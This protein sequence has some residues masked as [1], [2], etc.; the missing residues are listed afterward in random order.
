M[1]NKTLIHKQVYNITSQEDIPD[2]SVKKI[3]RIISSSPKALSS[4]SK[5]ELDQFPVKFRNVI[6]GTRKDLTLHYSIKGAKTVYKD[7]AEF[8]GIKY[9]DTI[10]Y[11]ESENT[12][13]KVDYVF[14]FTKPKENITE[15]RIYQIGPRYSNK[16]E[17]NLEALLRKNEKEGDI[18]ITITTL[19]KILKIN[20]NDPKRWTRLG[21]L[22]ISTEQYDNAIEACKRAIELVGIFPPAWICLGMAYYGKGNTEKAK[23]F[24]KKTLDDDP[25]YLKAIESLIQIYFNE[26]EY[27]KALEYCN[28]HLEYDFSDNKKDSKKIF[29]LREEIKQKLGIQEESP[30]EKSETQKNNESFL[31]LVQRLLDDNIEYIESLKRFDVKDLKHNAEG[32]VIDDKGLVFYREAIIKF[33]E[34]KF[35]TAF[36]DANR[37]KKDFRT[38]VDDIYP[39]LVSELE[40]FYGCETLINL[41]TSLISNTKDVAYIYTPIAIQEVLSFISEWAFKN[42]DKKIVFYSFWE[43]EL[44]D[45]IYSNMNNLGNIQV[46]RLWSPYSFFV[47]M[48]DE[49]ELILTPFS[50]NLEGIISIK[51]KDGEFVHFYKKILI[52]ILNGA[53]I[54]INF[55]ELKVLNNLNKFLDDLPKNQ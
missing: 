9:Y 45:K 11:E 4:Y 52:P 38:F 30:K 8:E 14:F 2:L 15:H 13:F 34:K 27:G 3:A 46:R 37:D 12:I 55:E 39:K 36:I 22:L 18:T 40:V 20:P 41:I 23:K 25:S 54:P 32:K 42:K 43:E 29:K 48:R 50:N 49:K 19:R 31:K 6:E 10:S 53:S 28:Q 17:T 33:F 51:S 35:I 16:E 7:P 47:A 44:F 21:E 24:I 26:K 5:Y 1:V